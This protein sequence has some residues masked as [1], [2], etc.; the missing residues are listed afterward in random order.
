MTYMLVGA[1]FK[2]TSSQNEV[3]VVNDLVGGNDRAVRLVT[4]AELI[5]SAKELNNKLYCACIDVRIDHVEEQC[6]LSNQVH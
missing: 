4:A 1:V 2:V 6:R 3:D 5:E